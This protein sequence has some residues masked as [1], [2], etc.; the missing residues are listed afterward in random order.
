MSDISLDDDQPLIDLP[1]KK[2]KQNNYDHCLLTFRAFDGL[3]DNM[4]EIM[5]WFNQ[6]IAYL[7]GL[8]LISDMMG[9]MEWNLMEWYPESWMHFFHYHFHKLILWKKKMK[10]EEIKKILHDALIPIWP[11]NK[12]NK[13][14]CVFGSPGKKQKATYINYLQKSGNQIYVSFGFEKPE[15]FT[16]GKKFDYEK[17]G[18]FNYGINNEDRL[19]NAKRVVLKELNNMGITV[20]YGLNYRNKFNKVICKNII[21]K[22]FYVKPSYAV[23][24]GKLG[25]YIKTIVH[26]P[27]VYLNELIK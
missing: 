3:R 18:K 25:K 12:F 22:L 15:M 21:Y 23:L 19:Y 17:V 10:K 27:E 24:F 8:D 20:T 9:V 4:E 5:Y 16:G 7:L 26:N 1:K 2:R 11:V 6:T 13:G 14:W